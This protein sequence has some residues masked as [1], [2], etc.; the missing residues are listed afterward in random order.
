MRP[1]NEFNNLIPIK[2]V[3]QP[4][5]NNDYKY[6]LRTGQPPWPPL[7]SSGPQWSHSLGQIYRS[8]PSKTLSDPQ[9]FVQIAS[10]TVLSGLNASRRGHIIDHY[11]PSLV[12]ISTYWSSGWNSIISSDCVMAIGMSVP[13]PQMAFF[14]H[15]SSREKSIVCTLWLLPGNKSWN[16]YGNYNCYE[17][18]NSRDHDDM[19]NS[20]STATAMVE[21][22]TLGWLHR[23]NAS[24]FQGHPTNS[25]GR[26]SLGVLY[27][28]GSHHVYT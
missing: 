15:Y 27:F 22:I 3:F 19:V 10:E 24:G 20:H 13:I 14:G 28:W 11:S 21:M 25:A 2:F 16:G 8:N 9:G 18:N 4:N 12:I 26:F 6:W 5:S 17:S 7:R 1:K 23:W